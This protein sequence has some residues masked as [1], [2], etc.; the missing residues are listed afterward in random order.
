MMENPNFGFLSF[1]MDNIL[2]MAS[3]KPYIHKLALLTH[4]LV[5]NTFYSKLFVL[6]NL[7]QI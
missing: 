5:I 3:G 7:K 2:K 4:L 6:P 1:S